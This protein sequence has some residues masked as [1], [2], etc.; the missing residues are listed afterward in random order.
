VLL[1]P[2]STSR[3]G[4]YFMRGLLLKVGRSPSR[5]FRALRPLRITFPPS[6]RFARTSKRSKSEG[7]C[8]AAMAMVPGP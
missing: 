1:K 2:L 4:P 6:A 5:R 7:G 3:C 8:G